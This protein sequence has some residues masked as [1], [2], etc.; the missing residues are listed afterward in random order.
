MGYLALWWIWCCVEGIVR[1]SI[2]SISIETV[3]IFAGDLR[4]QRFTD[5]GTL[6]ESIRRSSENSVRKKLQWC[7]SLCWV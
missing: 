2:V 6:P 4:W 5:T 1:K 7:Y 3:V